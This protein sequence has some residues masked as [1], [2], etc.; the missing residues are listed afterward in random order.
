MA[1][2]ALR[3]LTS[4]LDLPVAGGHAEIVGQDP[5]LQTNFR[6]GDA[7]AAALVVA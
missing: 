2:D 7:A 6:V 5:V 3:S 4:A 1:A